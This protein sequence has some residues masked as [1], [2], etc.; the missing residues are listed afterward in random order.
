VHL[1]VVQA[2]AHAGA[3]GAVLTADLPPWLAMV[4]LLLVGASLARSRRVPAVESF[5]LGDDGRLHIAGPQGSGPVVLHPHTLV[6]AF[7]V[8]LL[9]R[10]DGRLR[11]ITVLD[12]SLAPEDFRQ[13]RLWL[14]W[15]SGATGSRDDAQPDQG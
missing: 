9:Y 8:V 2:F 10:Q 15:R 5:T 11:S 13:L 4:F 7:M 3:A 1:Q 14:R 12:D 6:L